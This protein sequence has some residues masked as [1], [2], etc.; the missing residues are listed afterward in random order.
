MFEI[1]PKKIRKTNEIE[2]KI[3]KIYII[4]KF[5]SKVVNLSELTKKYLKK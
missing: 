4:Q 3:L 2:Q 5:N 1:T